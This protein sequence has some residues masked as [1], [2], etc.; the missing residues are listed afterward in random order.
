MVLSST[1]GF[2]SFGF[3]FAGAAAAPLGFAFAGA[4]ASLGFDFRLLY[5]LPWRY[6]LNLSPGD[7]RNNTDFISILKGCI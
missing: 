3:A 1:F 5:R 2:F 4:V 6:L 7:R